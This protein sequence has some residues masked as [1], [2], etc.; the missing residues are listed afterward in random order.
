MENMVPLVAQAHRAIANVEYIK[1]Y[2]SLINDP[3]LTEKVIS[4]AKSF[5]GESQ[6]FNMA[7][8]ILNGEDFSFIP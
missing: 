8:P 3:L 2:P 1:N 7:S 5:F 4:L 6:V